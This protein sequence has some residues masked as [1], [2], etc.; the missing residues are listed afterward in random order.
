M[1]GIA[2]FTLFKELRIDIQGTLQQMTA[3]LTHRGPDEEGAYVDQFIAIG[4]RRLSII[5]LSGGK[6]PIPNEDQ[7]LW[8]VFNGEIYNF[9]E[10]RE[11]LESRGHTFSTHTDTEVIVHLYEEHGVDC[12]SEL[13][14]MFA[15][16]IWDK[17]TQTLFLARDRLG[18][19]PLHYVEYAGGIIF[20]SEIKALLQH[21]L[22]EAQLDFKGLSKYLSYE[23]V[24]APHTMFKGIKKLGPGYWLTHT[25]KHTEI[26]QY[27]DIPLN[28]TG[29]SNKREEEHVEE[30]L[31]RLKESVRKRLISDVPIGVLLS[32]G[33]DS[34]SVA[35]LASQASPEPIHSFSIG[36]EEPS[37]DETRYIQKIV[38]MIGTRHHHQVLNSQKMIEIIPEVFRTL[39]EPVAES[40]I[41]PT[42]LLSKMT[43]QHVKVVLGGDGSDELFAGYQTYQAHKLVT[44]YSVLPDKLREMINRLAQRLPVSYKNTSFDFKVKQFLRGMGVSSEIRFFLWMGSFLECEKQQLFS[45]D[46]WEEHIIGMNP[47]EDVIRYVSDSNL[48]KEFERIL[49]LCMKLY[50]QDDILVK[51][52]RASMANSLEVRVPFLD[53]T[54]VEYAAK[55]PSRYKLNGFTTKYLLKKSVKGILPDDIIRRKK[56][57]FG[58]PLSKWFNEGLKE[59]LLSYL[60]EERIKK[61]GIF[62]YSYIRNL[63]DEHFSHTRDNRKQ[64]WALLVFEM[65]REQYHLSLS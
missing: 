48:Y 2:G 13:N 46:V 49:Y 57:G 23:Y 39:D 15:I 12:V 14:G 51:V 58:I 21:P 52:D 60:S 19:K 22:V 5:D 30:L 20:A 27:W 44:Y 53:H 24:P 28:E 56:K 36:F 65:W 33:I 35:V 42:Y 43:S 25:K 8:I 64:L 18:I 3:A 7:T 10:L 61:T 55:L 32:G 63:L 31:E 38:N 50:L 9:P 41:I 1:C 17:N 16:G 45:K 47:F 59:M 37:F 34:S 6:M 40:S 26:R 54:F 29:M 11:Q 4:S 62:E